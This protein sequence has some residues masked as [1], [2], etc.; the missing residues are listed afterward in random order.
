MLQDLETNCSLS[1]L[2]IAMV[3]LRNQYTFDKIEHLICDNKTFEPKNAKLY[4]RLYFMDIYI[5]SFRRLNVC[6]S[7][8]CI[9]EYFC[10]NSQLV[11]EFF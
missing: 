8:P 11:R 5:G 1:H 4:N 3:R 2:K 10:I 6:Y 9:S 7:M